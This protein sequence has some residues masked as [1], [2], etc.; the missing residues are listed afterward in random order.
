MR[1]CLLPLFAVHKVIDLRYL[2]AP[3]HAAVSMQ[4]HVGLNEMQLYQKSLSPLW[5]PEQMEP[6]AIAGFHP[7]P[8]IWTASWQNI[9]TEHSWHKP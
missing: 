8:T 5:P 2:N 7:D 6:L 1:I 9:C 4:N 3:W